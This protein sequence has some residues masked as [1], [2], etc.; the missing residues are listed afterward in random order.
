MPGSVNSGP[1]ADMLDAAKKRCE[2]DEARNSVKQGFEMFKARTRHG[3]GPSGRALLCS[4][5]HQSWS[6]LKCD[7]PQDNSLSTEARCEW[8]G[9]CVCCGSYGQVSRPKLQAGLDAA[10]RCTQGH[11]GEPNKTRADY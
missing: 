1:N 9:K 4:N 3:V 8:T 10:S 11:G 6:N 2:K 5:P 7:Q